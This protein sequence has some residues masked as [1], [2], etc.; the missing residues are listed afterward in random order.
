MIS[1]ASAT[2]RDLH[3]ALDRAGFYPR[4]VA[5]VL[6]D[7]LDGREPLSHLI[8]LETHFDR[9]EVHRHVTALVLTAD[10]LVIAH[11]DD[12]QLDELGEDMMAQVSTETVPVARIGSVVLSYM[13]HQPQNYRSTDKVREVS[14]GIAWS[15]GQRV[16]LAPAGC[17][18]PQCDSD[19][20]Y[21]GTLQQE[22]LVLRISAEADGMQAVEDAR[23]FAR[24]LRKLSTG[25]PAEPRWQ[26]ET[27]P[28]RV[29]PRFIRGHHQG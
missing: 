19:H 7:A 11:V 4:L 16:D 17:A 1:R 3:S 10:A 25:N 29:A 21:T 2:G 14:L 20:G 5:D 18:D 28:A 15:G 27:R 26:P 13:Y 9:T 8:H 22:D 23:H 24:A 12:Q 6:E